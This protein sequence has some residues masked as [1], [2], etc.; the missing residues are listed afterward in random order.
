VAAE[1]AVRKAEALGDRVAVA[2]VVEEGPRVLAAGALAARPRAVLARSASRG[3]APGA[4]IY[5]RRV[6]LFQAGAPA[7]SAAVA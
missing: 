1:E 3:A 5:R 4:A 2:P 6:S 7:P